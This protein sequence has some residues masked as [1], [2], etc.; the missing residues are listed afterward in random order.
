MRELKEFKDIHKGDDIYVIGS[1]ASVDYIDSGFFENK[2]TIGI[3]QIYKKIRT[4]YLVRKETKLLEEVLKDCKD[5]IHFI[6]NGDCGG[7]N[8]NNLNI[9][10]SKYK[11]NNKIVVYK[12]NVNKHSMPD[13]LPEDG[14]VVSYSTITTGIHLASYMG[15]KNIILVGHD[16]GTLDNK[17]NTD[18]Y[19]NDKS[20]KIVHKKGE[21]DYKK[22][23]GNIEE[24]TI[25]L[26]RILKDKNNIYSLNPFINF[27]LEGHV[28]K[29]G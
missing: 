15:C 26:K 3:N 29:K 28:Y 22:W 23:L 18:N 19:H 10:N 25:K 17:C 5:T 21:S 12:H 14:L 1:G 16:C 7:N 6:S 11:E 20:Y 8:N 27:N 9:I 4:T 24:Q 13:K 2:I